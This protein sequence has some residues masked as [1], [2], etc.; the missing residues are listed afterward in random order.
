MGLVTLVSPIVTL[1]NNSAYLRRNATWFDPFHRGDV[2]TTVF[3]EPLLATG[4]FVIKY[5][6]ELDAGL[7]AVDVAISASY[8]INFGINV[9]DVTITGP[10][11]YMRSFTVGNIP[12]PSGALLALTGC[13]LLRRRATRAR[14]SFHCVVAE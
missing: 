6:P 3:S 9:R 1:S 2:S 10:N 8:P 12:E 13:L 14:G 5:A 11:G 4:A 7:L